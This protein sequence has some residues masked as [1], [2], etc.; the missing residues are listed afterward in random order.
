MYLYSP[1]GPFMACYMVTFTF[2][3]TTVI[4]L[5]CIGRGRHIKWSALHPSH[6]SPGKRNPL[7]TKEQAGSAPELVWKYLLLLPEI[8]LSAI[9]V[10]LC[11]YQALYTSSFISNFEKLNHVFL[12]SEMHISTSFNFQTGV[13]IK[14]Q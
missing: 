3:L 14:F 9:Q 5:S 4:R 6:F 2:L 12:F 7:C 13:Y 11:L 1:C 8:E 10:Q